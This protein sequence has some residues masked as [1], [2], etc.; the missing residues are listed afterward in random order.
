MSTTNK[1]WVV[2]GS[3]GWWSDNTQWV[4]AVFATEELAK[5]RVELCVNW[6]KGERVYDDGRTHRTKD[7]SYDEMEELRCPYDSALNEDHWLATSGVDW[8]VGEADYYG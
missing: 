3:T 8:S 2:I 1:C 7:R 4:T 5:K 6:A